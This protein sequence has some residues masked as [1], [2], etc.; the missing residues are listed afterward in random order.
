MA[1][2]GSPAFDDD[3]AQVGDSI[4]GLADRFW[5]KLSLPMYLTKYMAAPMV[6]GVFI[7]RQRRPYPMVSNS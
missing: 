6:K 4:K 1:M 3:L 5:V 2:D 7:E